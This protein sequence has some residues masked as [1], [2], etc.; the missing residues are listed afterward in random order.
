[1]KNVHK[2]CNTRLLYYNLDSPGNVLALCPFP[3][4]LCVAWHSLDD[5]AKVI[6][7]SVQLSGD[8]SISGE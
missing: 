5:Y 6:E 7:F 2:L 4:S 8:N 3:K 1:M